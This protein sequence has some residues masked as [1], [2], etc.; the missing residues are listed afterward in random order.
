MNTKV[1]RKTNSVSHLNSRGVNASVKHKGSISNSNTVG[2]NAI[3]QKK[4]QQV[5][6]KIALFLKNKFS[7][8]FADKGYTQK[9]LHS[10]LNNMITESDLKN[11]DYTTIIIRIEKSVLDILSKMENIE[12]PVGLDLNK[13]N[14]LIQPVQKNDTNNKITPRTIRNNNQAG[15]NQNHNASLSTNKSV[16]NLYKNEKVQLLKEKASDEWALIAKLNYQ[17]HLEAEK[18]KRLKE[19]ESK[20]LQKQILENQIKE[21]EIYKKK[22]I[23]EN[24]RFYKQQ[25]ENLKKIDQ[26]EKQKEIENKERVRLEKE[27]HEKMIDQSK[28]SKEEK[29]K[30]DKIQDKI[31]LDK[32]KNEMSEQDEKVVRK[33][34]EEK[35]VYK[36]IIAENEVKAAQK[37][38]EKEKE[39]MENQKALEEYSK[40]IE[41]QEEER[42]NNFNNR[43]NK[44]KGQAQD[45][46]VNIKKKE[47]M[48]KLYEEQ[49]LRQEQEEK[50][51]R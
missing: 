14:S 6:E 43:L 28:K 48:I 2:G 32:I 4:K 12:V 8:L 37:K 17:K 15:K 18:E 9:Q 33:K 5:I 41:K 13:I 22:E 49:K 23:E 50:D 47:D 3:L 10:D 16:D 38:I 20:R 35:E 42:K 34:R 26:I 39:K 31:L 30:K 29:I 25:S 21:R 7:K 27:M 19:E 24:R 46:D 40:L 1:I 45:F 44:M 51:K 11:F 36:K